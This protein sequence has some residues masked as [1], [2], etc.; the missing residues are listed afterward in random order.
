MLR[1]L[2]HQEARCILGRVSPPLSGCLFLCLCRSVC[3][4]LSLCLS[5][6]FYL[7]RSPS[8]SLSLF[9]SFSWFISLQHP[10]PCTFFRS[11]NW[12]LPTL[13][14]WPQ[15]RGHRWCLPTA[16]PAF[17]VW[18]LRPARPGRAR[19]GMTLAPLRFIVQMSLVTYHRN[20]VTDIRPGA[21][22]AVLVVA[23]SETGET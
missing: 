16:Q 9:L 19:L 15:N 23:G 5:R 18:G 14:P 1:A 12:K 2:P 11:Q 22:L 7:S 3:L 6:S 20:S 21:M 13:N 4:S 10:G 17:I 8:R